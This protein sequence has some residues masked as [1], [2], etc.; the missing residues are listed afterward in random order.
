MFSLWL[1]KTNTN[2]PSTVHH[3]LLYL[4]RS[5]ERETANSLTALAVCH[6]SFPGSV[7]RIP[8]CHPLALACIPPLPSLSQYG[9]LNAAEPPRTLSL[10]GE[11]ALNAI[12]SLTFPNPGKLLFPN[13]WWNFLLLL[14]GS[15]PCLFFSLE[16]VVIRPW[17]GK[18]LALRKTDCVSPTSPILW[19]KFYCTVWMEY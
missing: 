11:L 7:S 14:T 2:F 9:I 17:S 4:L 16:N 3:R 18:G 15:H 13:A 10:W 8:S 12:Q 1:E 6:I 19:Q 5:R